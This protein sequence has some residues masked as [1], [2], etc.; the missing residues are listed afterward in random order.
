V[1]AVEE[2]G[3]VYLQNGV[4]L[5]PKTNDH[6]RRL[7]IVEHNVAEI[8]GDAIILEALALDRIWEGSVV[9]RF[10]ADWDEAYREFILS[11]DV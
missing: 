9:P 10:K 5:L 8:G 4:C 6:A 11:D 7:K 2:H 1:A 3:A